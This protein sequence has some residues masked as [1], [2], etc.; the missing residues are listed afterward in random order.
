MR[1][2]VRCDACSVLTPMVGIRNLVSC[3]N[4]AARID[5]VAKV[6]D[7]RDG[8]VTYPFGGYYDALAEAT[9]LLKDG[10]DCDDARDSHGS[11]VTLRRVAAPACPSCEQPLPIPDKG[12]ST[13]RCAGCSDV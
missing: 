3:R 12:A 4:C 9:L 6:K 5:F 10:E 7:S 8:G 13:L 1:V 11:P 2:S